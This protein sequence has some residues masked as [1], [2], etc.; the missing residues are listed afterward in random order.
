MNSVNANPQPA[1]VKSQFYPAFFLCLFLGG[2][3]AHRFY[4]GK[5]T[6]G[7]VQLVTLGGCGVWVLI[8]LITI[9][10]GKFKDENGSAIPNANPKVTWL[11][12][13]IPLALFGGF[14]VLG[15]L[16]QAAAHG[17]FGKGI[18]DSIAKEKADSIAKEKADSICL[19]YTSPS[20]RD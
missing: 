16:G 2:F 14:I 20:P 11:I 8:D 3:G 15:T 12:G 13:V 18:A 5:I 4:T 7:I 1:P 17:S 10:L 9:L 19:L 6:S